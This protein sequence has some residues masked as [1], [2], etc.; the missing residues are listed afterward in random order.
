VHWSD[1]LVMAW[2]RWLYWLEAVSTVR[3]STI[4]DLQLKDVYSHFSIQFGFSEVPKFVFCAKTS[5]LPLSPWMGV[6]LLF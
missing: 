1:S 5:S 2:G 4:W 3:S 6:S